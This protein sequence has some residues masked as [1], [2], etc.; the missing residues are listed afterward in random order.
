MSLSLLML[1]ASS[2]A[3][4]GY[5]FKK[6]NKWNGVFLFTLFVF[7]GTIQYYFN[8]TFVDDDVKKN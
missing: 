3:A 8:S 4:T 6:L 1:C 5:F 7:T 2:A